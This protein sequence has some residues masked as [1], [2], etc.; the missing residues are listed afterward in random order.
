MKKTYTWK[1]GYPFPSDTFLK[2]NKS[3]NIIK[4][5]QE[6]RDIVQVYVG[7]IH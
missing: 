2:E 6:P 1:E 5:I 4:V 3:L 7:T